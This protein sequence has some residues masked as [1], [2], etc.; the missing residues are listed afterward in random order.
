MSG[1]GRSS[2][3]LNVIDI[4]KRDD[5]KVRIDLEYRSPRESNLIADV[6]MKNVALLLQPCNSSTDERAVVMDTK[7]R[8]ESP[9]TVAGGRTIPSVRVSAEVECDVKYMKIENHKVIAAG[10][11]E[12]KSSCIRLRV[13]SLFVDMVN[14]STIPGEIGRVLRV[15]QIVRP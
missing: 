5:D 11:V 4:T 1:C 14:A 9:V 3:R 15:C 2:E 7:W 6:P 10:A 12:W 13:G 8:V